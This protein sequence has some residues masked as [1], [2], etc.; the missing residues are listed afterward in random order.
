[1]DGAVLV[2][3]PAGDYL[4]GSP[5]GSA[6]AQAD[7]MPQHWVSL[8]A[9]WIDLSEVTSAM[10]ARFVQA[11]GY[12]TEAERAGSG[13][14]LTGDTWGVVAGADWRHPLG[15]GSSLDGLE[16]HPVTLVSWSDAA[17]Y[18]AWA[19]RRL[20][21]E[22]EWEYAGRGALDGALYPWGNADLSGSR[23]NFA[24][25][26][27]GTGWAD[28]TI[29]DGWR[30]SA[31]VGSYPDGASPFGVL[32]LAGNVWEWVQDWYD[33]GAYAAPAAANPGGPAQGSGRILRGGG[34]SHAWSALRL[35]A[36]RSDDPAARSADVGFRCL[37]AVTQ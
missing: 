5:E 34:W 19:G 22:A 26:S 8:G 1:M 30:L 15:A 17:S 24:D 31:P 4:M 33:P 23:A 27:L 37:L 21:T 16:Q 6:G 3:L 12:V 29:N 28:L 10:F 11:T 25:A 14:V 7:E 18:C 13:S 2:Y 20:P 32:D 36:R 9:S 35:A